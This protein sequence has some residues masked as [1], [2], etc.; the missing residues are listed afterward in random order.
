MKKKKPKIKNRYGGPLRFPPA[1]IMK[2]RR[3]KR[4]RDKLRK[5][6]ENHD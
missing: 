5:E 1:G 3:K 2:D 4:E 6:M